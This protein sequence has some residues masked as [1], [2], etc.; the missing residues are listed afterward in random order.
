MKKLSL[1]QVTIPSW[2]DFRIMKMKR[3][4]LLKIQPTSNGWKTFGGANI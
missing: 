3:A 2:S 1:E 4:G